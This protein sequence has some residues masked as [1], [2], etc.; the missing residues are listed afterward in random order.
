MGEGKAGFIRRRARRAGRGAGSDIRADHDPAAPATP[1]K[2]SD[3][4]TFIGNKRPATDIQF[5]AA[6]AYY[7]R[8]EFPEPQRKETIA[9]DDLQDACRQTGRERFT[10]A[11]QTLVNAHHQGYLDKGTERG[12]YSINTVGE[13]LVA[14]ALPEG[15]TSGASSVN[16]RRRKLKPKGGKKRAR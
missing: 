2:A 16:A 11:A 5:A 6:V 8:F 14:M 3:I 13:N 9:A 1:G 7:Y 15:A 10:R 4:R 12:T